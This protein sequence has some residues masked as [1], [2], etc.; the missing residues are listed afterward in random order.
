MSYKRPLWVFVVG[1]G[2][3]LLSW[4]VC[5]IYLN[6]NSPHLINFLTSWIPLVFS[7]LFAFVPSGKD[8]KHGWIKWTWR[9]GVITVG[10]FCSVLLWHQQAINDVASTQQINQA[11]STA[12]SSANQHTDAKVGE[13]EGDVKGISD[14]NVTLSQA[15][16]KD[17]GDINTNLGK[18]GKPDPPV[19]AVLTFSLWASTASLD[20]PVMTQYIQ[21]DSDG[22]FPID[23]SFG[24]NSQTT[25]KGID[26]WITICDACSFAKEP[27]G[28]EHPAGGDD[29]T[30]HRHIG[31]LNPGMSFEKMTIVVKAPRS[32]TFLIAFRYSCENCGGKMSDNQLATITE[33]I[34]GPMFPAKT[35]QQQ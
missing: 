13:V 29:R 23:F 35:I 31:D 24:D 2:L 34:I 30:R 11:I 25:A 16:A 27:T 1:V 26:I 5:G 14:Q 33:G 6:W 12:V 7:I 17:T 10:L 21:P 20:K 3:C 19:P 32:S 9:I 4:L 8:I 22:N 18:V 28:F 15:L